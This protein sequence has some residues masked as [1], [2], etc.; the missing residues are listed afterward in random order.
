MD[1]R[2]FTRYKMAVSSTATDY[3]GPTKVEVQLNAD[4][5]MYQEQLDAISECILSSQDADV[6]D[7][8]EVK[9]DLQQLISITKDRILELA[10][11]R[12]L[13][14]IDT[15]D[16]KKK[17][18][19]L[20]IDKSAPLDQY[21]DLKG[22]RCQAPLKESWG[23]ALYHNAMIHNRLEGGDGADFNVT[24]LFTNPCFNFMKVCPFF[25]EGR[26]KFT[27]ENCRYS[28]GHVVSFSDL[29]PYYKPDYSN[30]SVGTR[31]LVKQPD[32]LWHEATVSFIEI[33]KVV[34]KFVTQKQDA[35]VPL[36]DV[37]PLE[38]N[39][40]SSIFEDLEDDID[41][42]QSK[43][44]EH[45][46]VQDIEFNDIRQLE[47]STANRIGEWEKH[48]KGI[49]SKLMAKMGYVT[50]QGLGKSSDGRLEP[51]KI[52][53]LP[54]G[55]SLDA[56]AAMRES[57]NRPSKSHIK[58]VTKSELEHSSSDTFDFLNRTISGR[59][60][61]AHV[62][63]D[64]MAKRDMKGDLNLQNLP[65]IQNYY[66]RRKRTLPFLFSLAIKKF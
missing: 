1:M 18:E 27:S 41:N 53:I 46:K 58:K 62:A 56:C 55:K 15:C 37:L 39:F 19:D 16:D 36:A 48:T 10:K 22:M 59:S 9:N 17:F 6:T 38:E 32:E 33:D 29:K 65:L 7:F 44:E 51:V 45:E 40:N 61:H 13:Q 11:E 34:V 3:E 24:V 60:K 50:G 31:C 57:K 52:E 63:L 47:E 25:L 2:A 66:E 23:T 30:I 49:G 20:C 14:S 35:E 8:I 43:D 5:K 42:E 12:L 54:P 4:L 21:G 28:H 64:P 26:C